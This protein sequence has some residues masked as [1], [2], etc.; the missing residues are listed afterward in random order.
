MEK[1]RIYFC[2]DM[3]SFFASVECAELGLNP[4]ETNLIVADDSRGKGT[5]CLAITPKMKSL[6]IK[7]RCRVYEI[8]NNVKYITAKPRMKKYIEYAADI[9]EIY[10]QYMSPEDIYVYSIDE[11]FLDVTDYL[12]MYNM[13]AKQFAKMLLDEIAK[14]KHIPA[15][16]GIGTNLYLAKIALDITAKTAKDHLG[17]LTEETFRES[18]WKHRP[19]TDFWGIGVGIS[20]RLARMGIFDMEGITKTQPEKL[21]KAFGVN[22]E[23]I[24]DHAWGKETCLMSDIKS[25]KQKSKSI[26]NSQVLFKDYPF[27]QAKLVLSEMTLKACHDLMRQHLIATSVSIYVGYSKDVAAPTGKSMKLINATSRYSVINEVVARLY[28]ESTRTNCPI[29][30]LGISLNGLVD[31]GCE[32]YDLFTNFEEVEKE[33][34]RESVVLELQD[35]YG[36]NAVLRCSDLQEGATTMERNKLIGGHNSE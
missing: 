2:I 19:L 7:N 8:P 33:K 10:L 26:S 9:Y 18:L 27:S 23:L 22:A 28:D 1:Q 17:V 24:I 36:K 5:V 15:T 14:K 30:R 11:A 13:R 32:G 6:G 4:F 31:E 25:Y 29:R 34:R 16:C 12:S 20:N 35:K 3:K 21:Y